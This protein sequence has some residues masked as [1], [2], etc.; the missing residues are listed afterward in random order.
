MNLVIL[1]CFGTMD[2]KSLP[3]RPFWVG[4]RCMNRIAR[5]ER[6]AHNHGMSVAR[7]REICLTAEKRYREEG[8][9]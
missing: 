7:S 4:V 6:V 3:D 5:C 9:Q 8:S 1:F 2:Y